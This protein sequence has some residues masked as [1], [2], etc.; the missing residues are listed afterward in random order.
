MIFPYINPTAFE[1]FGIEIKWYGI[2]YAVGLLL[3]LTY[4]KSISNETSFNGS[5]FSKGVGC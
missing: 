5:L 1:L 3:A 4:C 2:S